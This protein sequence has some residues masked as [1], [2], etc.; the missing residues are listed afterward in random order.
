M[1]PWNPENFKRRKP[2]NIDPISL[3]NIPPNTVYFTIPTRGNRR[4]TI[5]RRTLTRLLLG[6]H[7]SH[8]GLQVFQVAPG[9][10]VT[11]RELSNMRKVFRNQGFLHVPLFKNPITRNNV[12]INQIKAH[13]SPQ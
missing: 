3:N 1:N 9:H 7:P 2:N 4:V 11:P 5:N 8:G 6:G 13:A 10:I 12:T